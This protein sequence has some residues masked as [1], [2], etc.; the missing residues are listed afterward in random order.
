MEFRKLSVN[1]FSYGTNERI[2]DTDKIPHVDFVDKKFDPSSAEDLMILLATCHTIITEEKDGQIEYKASSPDEL[3]LVNSARFFGYHFVGRD[4]DQNALVKIGNDI[5]KIQILN[6]LEFTSD[7]KRMSVVAR[8]PDGKIKIFCKG[9][10]TILLPRLVKADIIDKTWQHLEDYANEGLR[11]LVLA[12]RDLSESEYRSWNQKFSEA[13]QDILNREKRIGEVGELIEN[14]LTLLGATAIEDKLQDRVPETIQ[15]LRNAGVKVWVLTGDKMETA[16][17]IG[18]SCNL[19]TSDMARIVVQSSHSE[20]VT[21]ELSKG[22]LS[23]RADPKGNFALIITGDSLIKA[24]RQENISLLLKVTDFCNV[25]VA[26]RVSPQ[27][28]ADIVKLIKDNKKGART[29][30]IGDGANDVNMINAAH[31]GVGIAGLEGA[32]AVRASDYSIGQFY[33][34]QRLMFVHGRES[35]RKNS[36]LICYNFYKNVLLVMPLFFYGIFS[37]YSGQ[38]FYNTWL[39]QLYNMM[40]SAFP[41]ITYAIFDREIPYSTLQ[42]EPKYYKI[43]LKGEL[44]NTNVF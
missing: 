28:K 15:M 21:E 23:H 37:A 10:D 5:I 13:M 6:V 25:V 9:A 11:T 7:R 40:F 14:N 44:F 35:Y 12:S 24:M 26:C 33:Y 30:S 29:L 34:L 43:G 22:I 36:T 27:Q 32:Q 17:N 18:F 16:I 2:R 8:L 1:G 4:S 31:V 42:N 3:A 38:P 39:Y 20:D 19:L 41:I